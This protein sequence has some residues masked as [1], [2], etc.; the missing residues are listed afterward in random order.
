[1]KSIFSICFLLIVSALN[2]QNI[3][4]NA[5]NALLDNQNFV[6]NV[7]GTDATGRAMYSTTPVDGEPCSGIGTCEFKIQWSTTNSRWELIADEGNGTFESPFLIYSNTSA[8]APFPPSLLLGVWQENATITNNSCG[9]ALTSS[10]ATLTGDVQDTLLSTE[11]FDI[12][13]TIVVYPNPGSSLVNIK[14]DIAI[15]EVSIFNIQGQL[16]LK[17][18]E[19]SFY[20]D[21]LSVGSYLIKIK[22][23]K[24]FK[25]VKYF[26]N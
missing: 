16:V 26:K 4:L 21:T 3:T 2:A 1:M 23:E 5:C 20:L 15:Q 7:S 12:L 8:S 19:T 13:N 10:N 22:T 11:D 6:F 25:I 14:S 18:Y 24:G 9:G 17:K